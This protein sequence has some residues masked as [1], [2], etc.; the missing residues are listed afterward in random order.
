MA[1]SDDEIERLRAEAEDR[2]SEEIEGMSPGERMERAF[3]LY[4]VT[5]DDA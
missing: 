1:L 3:E 5:R 2:R 4:L